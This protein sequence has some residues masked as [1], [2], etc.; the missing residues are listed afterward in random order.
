MEKARKTYIT[1]RKEIDRLV[2][3]AVDRKNSKRHAVLRG[4][5]FP[6]GYSVNRLFDELGESVRFVDCDLRGADFSIDWYDTLSCKDC[7]LRG[8]DLTEFCTIR[9]SGCDMRKCDLSR[10]DFVFGHRIGSCDA[11]ELRDCDLRGCD[12][13]GC[14]FDGISERSKLYKQLDK[15][16][17]MACPRKGKY[18][19]YKKLALGWIAELEIPASAKRS[20]SVKSFTGMC[21]CRASEAVVKR[22]YQR[23]G[24]GKVITQKEGAS[25][26]RKI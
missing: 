8:Q 21:K 24:G 11:D 26:I 25:I 6:K 10:M 7:D 22:I 19:A 16:I 4:I 18:T 20:S 3:E 9:M 1:D 14:D 15:L 5:R 17:P 12:F 23:L 13:S 2:A